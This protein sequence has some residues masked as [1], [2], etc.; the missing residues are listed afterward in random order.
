MVGLTVGQGAKL[1]R[2]VGG[3]PRFLRP[4]LELVP[5]DEMSMGGRET[6]L[7]AGFRSWTAMLDLKNRHLD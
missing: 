4:W 7:A 5:T 1:Q 2:Q 3:R 6:S